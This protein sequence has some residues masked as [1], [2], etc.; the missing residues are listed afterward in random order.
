[1]SEVICASIS[2]AE[3]ATIEAAH[4]SAVER[5]DEFAELVAAFV[6]RI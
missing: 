6:S 4:L 1:M 3:L 2:G 5:P